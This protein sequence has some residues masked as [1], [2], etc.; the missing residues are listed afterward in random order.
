MSL[1]LSLSMNL[2][3]RCGRSA[4]EGPTIHSLAHSLSATLDYIRQKLME[5]PPSNV[6]DEKVCLT[7]IWCYFAPYEELLV[8]LADLCGRVRHFTTFFNIL[9][10]KLHPE[11]ILQVD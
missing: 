2:Q 7:Q 11:R 4:K 10:M 1:L 5:C 8:A 9:S 6:P 3:W